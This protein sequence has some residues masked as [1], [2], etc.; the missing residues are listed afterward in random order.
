MKP[1]ARTKIAELREGVYVLENGMIAWFGIS[2]SFEPYDRFPQTAYIDVSTP[3][4]LLLRGGAWSFSDNETLGHWCE[5]NG[6]WV[7]VRK[8]D[9]EVWDIFEKRDEKGRKRLEKTIPELR[10]YD[11]KRW[12]N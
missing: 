9:D 6:E 3:D 10:E 5:T 4:G 8:I 1:L 12:K 7:P 2:Y 11:F